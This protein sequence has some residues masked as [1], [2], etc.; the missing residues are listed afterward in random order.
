MN[1]NNLLSIQHY[2]IKHKMST[3]TVIKQ[4]NAGQLKTVKKDDQDFIID[5][6]IPV[7]S[8]TMPSP[9][10]IEEEEG[11]QNV[12]YEAKFHEL[13]SKYIDLQEKYTRLVEEKYDAKKGS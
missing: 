1:K 10:A 5:D 7:K 13:L 12:D 6:S 2:A 11:Q 8:S 4:I 9:N 3:F